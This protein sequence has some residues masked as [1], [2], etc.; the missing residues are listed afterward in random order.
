VL[1]AL[2]PGAGLEGV[3]TVKISC[4]CGDSNTG[5]FSTLSSRYAD[6]ATPTTASS[7]I[8]NS[9]SSRSGGGVI[10]NETEKYL[11]VTN[12]ESNGKSSTIDIMP[13]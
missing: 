6:C 11:V 7:S 4:S 13:Y 12:V 3:W 2:G 5:P 8:S 9:S 1:I 10:E